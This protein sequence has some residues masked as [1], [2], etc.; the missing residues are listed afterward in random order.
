MARDPL[1][2]SLVAHQAFCPRRAWLEAAGESTDTHQMAVGLR[3]HAS[4]DDPTRSRSGSVRAVDLTSEELDVVGRCDTVEVAEDGSL[5]VIE[6]K[7]TPVRRRAEVT[8]PMRMQ[9]A[10]PG[11]VAPR[12]GPRWS[13]RRS[14]RRAWLPRRS[15]MAE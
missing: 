6:H 12:R 15:S 8:E 1:P 2:I 11:R 9:L 10:G 14:R 13:F 3:A 7:S 5:V 4:S